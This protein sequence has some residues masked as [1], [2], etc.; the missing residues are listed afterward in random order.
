M[1]IE[2]FSV[3]EVIAKHNIPSRS[4]LQRWIQV[5]NANREL[6]DYKPIRGIY[7]FFTVGTEDFGNSTLLTVPAKAHFT[8]IPPH[9][10]ISGKEEQKGSKI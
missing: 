1:L 9:F 2:G 6:K 3:N 4:V 8:S 7:M 10:Q 5:Y